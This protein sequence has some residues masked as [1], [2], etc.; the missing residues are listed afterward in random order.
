MNRA[1]IRAALEGRLSVTAREIAVALGSTDATPG[2]LSQVAM[3]M[4]ALH[5]RR[6]VKVR[7][8]GGATWWPPLPAKAVGVEPEVAEPV[9]RR[10]AGLVRLREPNEHE[11]WPVW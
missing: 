3:T 10:R 6:G 11:P 9:V 5:W 4:K 1:D 2:E 7:G 8:T